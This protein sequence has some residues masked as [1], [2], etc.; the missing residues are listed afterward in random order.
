MPQPTLLRDLLPSALR[1]LAT[2]ARALGPRASDQDP[3]PRHDAPTLSHLLVR[4]DEVHRAAP[5]RQGSSS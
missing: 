4:V 3:L 1:A 5:S 2:P